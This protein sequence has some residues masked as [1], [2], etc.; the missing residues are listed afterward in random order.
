MKGFWNRS[1]EP[2][3]PAEES[4]EPPPPPPPPPAPRYLVSTA[5]HP[6]YGD[7]LITRAWL[8]HLAR[9]EPDS[10]VWIDCP[11]PGRAAHLFAGVHQRAQF[12]NTLWELAHSSPS[13]DPVSD[14]ERIARIVRHLGSPR[15]DAGIVALRRMRSLHLLGGGYLNSMWHD[16]LGLVAAVV[17]VS[18]AFE[19]PIY[20]TGQ[21][22]TP[23]DERHR[24]W[25]RDLVSCFE[26][27]EVRDAESAGA[28]GAELG[29]DDA[30]LALADGRSPYDGADSPHKMVLVQGDLKAWSDEEARRSIAS[31]VGEGDDVG[32][33]EAIPP[34]DLIYRDAVPGE[35][36]V[37]PFGHIWVDGLPAR[38]GQEWLTTRFHIHLMAAA[39]GAAGTVIAGLPGYYDVKHESLL[40]LGTG[41]NVI[42]AGMDLGDEAARPTRSDEFPETARALAAQKSGLAC[43]IYGD[44]AEDGQSLSQN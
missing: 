11:H 6:N 18:R 5:G 26:V 15:F 32:V 14:T 44:A 40:A 24:D 42:A 35:P 9:V 34:D 39:A 38:A 1:P 16:N 33:V 31:F 19:V 7:E 20:A 8:E 29:I 21:G 37:Y 22:M 2:D 3:P 17:E 4:V 41:W 13:H 23:L 30:F 36:R 10:D 12:T 43:R 27:F 25:I 28:T